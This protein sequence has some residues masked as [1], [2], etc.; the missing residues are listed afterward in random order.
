MRTRPLRTHR[1]LGLAMAVV[2][3]PLFL[4][5][6]VDP[7]SDPANADD[8]ANEVGVARE[9][10]MTGDGNYMTVTNFKETYD[11]RFNCSPAYT[12]YTYSARVNPDCSSTYSTV[13][14][15]MVNGVC[16]NDPSSYKYRVVITEP[17]GDGGTGQGCYGGNDGLPNGQCGVTSV[18][19]NNYCRYYHANLTNIPYSQMNGG[20]PVITDYSG[21]HTCNG[22]VQPVTTVYWHNK[23]NLAV[24]IWTYDSS[25][26]LV[27]SPSLTYNGGPMQPHSYPSGTYGTMD[28]SFTSWPTWQ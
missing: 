5:C 16:V 12:N 24:S 19:I 3:A 20:Y 22:V 10:L 23:S 11:S 17:S 15:H 25:G 27:A 6:A 1:L 8:P 28:G 7:A 9:K 2:A 13:P 18:C 4:G 21:S 26:A 14:S